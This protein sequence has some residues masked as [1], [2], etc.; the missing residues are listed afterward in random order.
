MPRSKVTMVNSQ[1][2]LRCQV[3]LTKKDSDTNELLDCT[4]CNSSESLIIKFRALKTSP[5]HTILCLQC[6]AEG[7]TRY[8]EIE[9][10]EAWNKERKET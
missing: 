5:L 9:A 2:G 10:V 1:L 3:D 7:P 6:R 4:K 8:S